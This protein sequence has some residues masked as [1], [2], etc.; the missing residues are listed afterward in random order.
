M[1]KMKRA[2]ALVLALALLLT[3]APGFAWRAAEE[4]VPLFQ[5]L[6]RLLKKTC[7]APGTDRTAADAAVDG[8]RIWRL[9]Y[10]RPRPGGSWAATWDRSRFT[11]TFDRP[12]KLGAMAITYAYGD[13]R[14]FPVKLE[15]SADGK[16]YHR[17]FDGMSAH[18]EKLSV[19]RWKPEQVRSIR[20]L[21]SGTTLKTWTCIE[22]IDFPE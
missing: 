5:D 22:K 8:G 15:V 13:I 1:T 14:D 6:L 19:F 17:V 12:V 9:L 18:Q 21:G 10:A 2:A 11:L 4:N 3:A 16:N 20:Y 7:D